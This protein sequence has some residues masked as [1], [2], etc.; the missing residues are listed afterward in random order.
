MNENATKIK[1]LVG[2]TFNKLE[3]ESDASGYLYLSN[4][5]K[6]YISYWRCYASEKSKFSSFDDKQ[7]YG[8]AVPMD[9]LNLLK[10]AILNV[11]I[12]S[13]KLTESFFD[14]EIRLVNNA[15]LQVFNFTGNEVWEVT[16][17]D[18]TTILS[19]YF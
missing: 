4:G 13:I 3:K 16:F 6:I 19:N 2:Q 9:S 15:V 7:K 12:S 5:A 1:S 10:E 14:I 17:S 11:E 18:G 8:F